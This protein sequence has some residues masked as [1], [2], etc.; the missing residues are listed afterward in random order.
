MKFFDNFYNLIIASE[1]LFVA[2]KR[3]S[4]DKRKKKDV[5]QF[6]WNLEQNIF[7]LYRELKYK[8]YKHGAY[9]SFYITDPKQ[10]HIHKATVRDRVLHHSIVR[11]LTPLFELTF[12]ANSFSCRIGKGTHRGVKSVEKMSRI[13]SQNYTRDC[14]GLKCDVEKFFDSVDHAVLISILKRRIKDKDTMWLLEEVIDSFS[15]GYSNLFDKKGIPIGNLTSQLFANVYMNEFDQ[16]IK[17]ELQV[18]HYARYTDDLVILSSNKE[19]LLGLLQPIQE[20]LENKLHLALHPK[21]VS[22]RSLH[23]GI[24]FLGYIIFPHHRLLRTKTKNRVEKGFSKRLKAQES[25][26]IESEQVTKSLYSY[27]GLLSHANAHR[28]SDE[29]KNKLWFWL[30][31]D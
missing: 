31:K 24:D 16:F 27:L 19:Y 6:E 28:F 9:S 21:K 4:R 2:W 12:I 5:L 1:S 25:G 29:L 13:V 3:F 17:H 22:I 8:T 7:A 30:Q 10:R 20:F 11:V 15:S 23:N 14:F 26:E 18:K